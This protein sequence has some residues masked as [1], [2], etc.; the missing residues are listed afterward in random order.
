MS[1]VGQSGDAAAGILVPDDA[2]EQR[3]A[4]RRRHVSHG[5]V[6][7]G[8]GQGVP[9]DA[10]E[11]DHIHAAESSDNRV[12]QRFRLRGIGAGDAAFRRSGRCYSHWLDFRGVGYAAAVL[13][14][15]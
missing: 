2:A 8:D 15:D 7:L 12:R 4:A 3:D 6:H 1:L 13:L 10:E 9:A 11:P 5:R 14:R